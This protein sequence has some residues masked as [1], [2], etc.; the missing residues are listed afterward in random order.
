MDYWEYLA[1]SQKGAERE[2]HRYY[3]RELVGNKNGRAIYRYFYTAQEYA[4]YKNGRSGEKKEH[5]RTE[6]GNG[7]P[8]RTPGEHCCSE[9]GHGHGTQQG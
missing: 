7:P 2:N 8:P 1:H 5:W 9:E 4:A 6:S 3:A